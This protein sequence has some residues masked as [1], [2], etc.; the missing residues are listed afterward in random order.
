[1]ADIDMPNVIIHG[2]GVVRRA[3]GTIK[4][5]FTLSNKEETEGD[6]DDDST[7]NSPT[8]RHSESD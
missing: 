8:R 3:D 4:A 2:T 6:K 1:M 5:E 7:G